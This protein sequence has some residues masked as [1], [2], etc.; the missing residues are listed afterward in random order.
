M[1]LPPGLSEWSLVDSIHTVI[2]A[3]KLSLC[4]PREDELVVGSDSVV[5]IFI[6]ASLEPKNI[7]GRQAH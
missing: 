7:D 2:S 6:G 4:P 1:W 5:K 3:P